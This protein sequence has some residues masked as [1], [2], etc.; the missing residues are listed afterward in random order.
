MARVLNLSFIF[1]LLMGKKKAGTLRK[2]QGFN[3][4]AKLMISAG[5]VNFLGFGLLGF[6]LVLYLK[7]LGY[8]TVVYGS[9]LLVMEISNVLVLLASG[10]MADRLGRK[11]MLILS[12]ILGT[13]GYGLFAF[14]DTMLAFTLAIILLG[15][16]S[17]FWGPAFNALMTVKAKPKRR[18]Y[19]FSLNSIVGNMGS[20]FITLIGG[21]IPIFFIS[22]FNFQIEP[23]YQMIF[24][25][26]FFLKI[27]SVLII[28]KIRPDRT[29]KPKLDAEGKPEKKPWLLLLKFSLPAVFTGIGA[30]M[31]VPYF[32]LYFDL[33]FGLDI[34]EI[35]IFF[36]ILA[37]VM[38][39][40]TIYL[41][42]L[43]E[44]GGTVLTTTSFHV[45]AI[46]AMISIPFTPWLA[47]VVF[48][49][50]FR[51]ALM[52]VPGPIMTS[53]MMGK[54]PGTARATAN[55]SVQ[56]S[57][58][59]THAVGVFIGGFLWEMDD[60]KLPF[61]IATSLYIISTIL[62][63][64]FFVRTDDGEKETSMTWPWFRHLFRRH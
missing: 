20:G 48:L 63:F 11:K 12:A 47:G 51:A 56:F 50:V 6:S 5:L 18:K 42:R 29:I 58:I 33:R 3:R 22:F 44:R 10:A 57:W 59:L 37:F 35:G 34:A 49:F 15:A 13:I 16:S 53:F 14:F 36:A 41:P 27:A 52:N 54:I 62:Y 60:L 45:I 28:I 61:Y 30:G 19:L 21:F 24:F 2:Y 64:S 26:A 55:S 43:A 8:S 23:A 39:I 7:V 32:P 40:M 38:A 46:L 1:P 31:L 17:G 25:M 4:D 9:L